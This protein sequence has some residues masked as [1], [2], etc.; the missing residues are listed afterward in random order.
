MRTF[1]KLAGKK[2]YADF[3]QVNPFLRVL[4]WLMLIFSL[5]NA[6]G[7][8]MVLRLV[9]EQAAIGPE[10]FLSLN[11]GVFLLILMKDFIPSYQKVVLYDVAYFPLRTI[12]KALIWLIG[13]ELSF[14]NLIIIL[15]LLVVLISPFFQLV[16]FLGALLC[17]VIAVQSSFLLRFQFDY[18]YPKQA[19]SAV[20]ALLG[21]LF[22]AGVQVIAFRTGMTGSFYLLALLAVTLVFSLPMVDIFRLSA[23][24]YRSKVQKTYRLEISGVSTGLRM[25]A[26]LVNSLLVGL[27]FKV[28][29][30]L[31]NF[32]EL[33]KGQQFLFN[34]E[35]LFV[36]LLP[37]TVLF[38]YGFNNYHAF[39]PN[40]F[41]NILLRTGSA[42]PFF[43]H[44]IREGLLFLLLDLS[45]TT[46]LLLFFWDLVDAL[47]LIAFYFT[48]ALFLFPTGLLGS[49]YFP[50]KIEKKSFLANMKMYA[51]PIV[52]I[53]SIVGVYLLYLSRNYAPYQIA[54]TL[55][56]GGALLILLYQKFDTIKYRFITTTK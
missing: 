51:H 54:I 48:C 17:L 24:A 6:V 49:L 35:F 16:H 34:S 52:S 32:I 5:I 4:R 3:I 1:I 13:N 2:L 19:V 40:Y 46:G 28:L 7:L 31:F 23:K 39:N 38:T 44:F 25:P 42:S 50:V 12:H 41:Y 9:Q 45:I 27:G 14:F 37:P 30:L 10:F 18:T 15:N 26:K 55:I 56:L 33:Q 36:L 20:L 29:L 8:I 53:L 21:A 43:R 11:L 22:F 47:E